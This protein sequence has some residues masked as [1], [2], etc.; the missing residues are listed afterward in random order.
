MLFRSQRVALRYNPGASPPNY[1]LTVGNLQVENFAGFKDINVTGTKNRVVDTENY[2][3]VLLNAY[4]TPKPTFADTG[5]AQIDDDGLCYIDI[6][7][8]FLETID[9]THDYRYFLTKYGQGDIWIKESNTDYFIV[10]GTPSLEFDWKIEAVQRDYNTYNL[11]QFE[12]EGQGIEEIDYI[13]LADEYL[14]ENEKE[15]I[16]DE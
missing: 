4:E 7:L 9:Q 8:V 14:Q 12:G 11:E 2:G 15:M 6:G 10:E 3:R 13:S 1:G 5:H 16:P